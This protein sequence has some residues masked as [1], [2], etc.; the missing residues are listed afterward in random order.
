MLG[1]ASLDDAQ[2]SQEKVNK[3]ESVQSLRGADHSTRFVTQ[4]KAS[5]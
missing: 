3:A 2:E 4:N 1:A 5:L